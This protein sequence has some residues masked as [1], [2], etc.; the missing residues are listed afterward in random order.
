M[1]VCPVEHRSILTDTNLAL[2]KLITCRH[3]SNAMTIHLVIPYMY[4]LYTYI[5]YL[6]QLT[7]STWNILFI[8]LR[9]IRDKTLFGKENCKSIYSLNYELFIYYQLCTCAQLRFQVIIQ[10]LLFLILIT[11]ISRA[12]L[13]VYKENRRCAHLKRS[14]MVFF[15]QL[16]NFFT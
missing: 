4:V 1:H 14:S 8:N 12:C 9:L 5:V 13:L 15:P 3:V 16:V 2:G 6:N 11:K 10:I 7:I